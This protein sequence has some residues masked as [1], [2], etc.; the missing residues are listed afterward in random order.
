[1]VRYKGT[2]DADGVAA[3]LDEVVVPVRIAC[4]TPA[5]GLWIV[6]LWYRREQGDAPDRAAD[7]GGSTVGDNGAD[8]APVL[9]CATG[10]DAEIVRYLEQDADVAFEV[11]TDRP[12]YRG[13]RGSG[14]VDIAPDEEKAT[15]RALL[16]RYLGGT[17]SALADRLLASDRDEVRLTLRPDRVYSWDFSDSM[18]DVAPTPS[19]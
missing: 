3:F 19:E 15:L 9:R 1:M 12:P 5:G 2:W 7:G 13:V 8:G 16:E 10:A 17:D 18:A 14:T 6:S 11:S 4:R